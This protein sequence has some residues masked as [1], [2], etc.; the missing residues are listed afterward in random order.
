M[1]GFYGVLLTLKLVFGL[2]NGL[3]RTPPSK[4]SIYWLMLLFSNI[5]YLYRASDSQNE[6]CDIFESP[7]NGN[8]K[9]YSMLSL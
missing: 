7:F 2:D 1:Y 9:S 6:V 3:A 5:Y 4:C 8:T